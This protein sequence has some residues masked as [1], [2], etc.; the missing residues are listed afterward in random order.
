MAR[1]AGFICRLYV[2]TRCARRAFS[3]FVHECV[4]PDRVVN[5][6]IVGVGAVADATTA[7][8][9]ATESTRPRRRPFI[10]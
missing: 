5:A 7:H 6:E 10:R 9:T 4:A 2:A 1:R 8:T 3:A